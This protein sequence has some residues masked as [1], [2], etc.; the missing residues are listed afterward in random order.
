MTVG[1]HLFELADAYAATYRG[2]AGGAQPTGADEADTPAPVVFPEL[3]AAEK[4][5]AHRRHPGETLV[6]FYSPAN[7]G[8]FGPALQLVTDQAA[9]LMDSVK[10]GRAHV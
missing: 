7:D 2:P 6:R 5:L 8:G 10:I 3:I 1:P 4:D 9:M